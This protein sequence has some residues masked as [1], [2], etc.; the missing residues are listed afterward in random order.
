MTKQYFHENLFSQIV[1]EPTHIEGNLIDQANVRDVKEINNYSTE[2]HS[3][4]YT[5]HKGIAV[6]I[7]R[8]VY[9]NLSNIEINKINFRNCETDFS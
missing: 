6:L 7:K 4:Y 5:D 3:K 2:I 8:L 9:I 1:E